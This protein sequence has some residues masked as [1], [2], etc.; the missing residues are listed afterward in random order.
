MAFAYWVSSLGFRS[1]ENSAWVENSGRVERGLDRPH[2]CKLRR[3]AGE[4]QEVALAAANPMFRRHRTVEAGDV[5]VDHH[6][7]FALG[8]GVDALS[9]CHQVQ[10]RIRD[11][12]V[13][14]LDGIGPARGDV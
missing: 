6:L 5:V 12:A 1:S 13:I 14:D 7:D 4:R 11:M 2:Q 3:A 9:R 10:V 8:G